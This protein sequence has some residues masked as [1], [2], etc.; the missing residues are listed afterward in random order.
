MICNFLKHWKILLCSIKLSHYSTAIC[1]YR[2]RIL[3]VFVFLA[4]L[5]D[6][7]Y[8]WELPMLMGG[9]YAI[10][11][12][13][14]EVHEGVLALGLGIVD[15]QVCDINLAAHQVSLG[16]LILLGRRHRLFF[17]VVAFADVVWKLGLA[18]AA[19]V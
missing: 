15:L 2:W 12:R 3:L 4:V 17:G 14:I 16:R 8:G 7:E 18:F 11:L 1:Y 5:I 6:L 10:V 19:D 13:V 9:A